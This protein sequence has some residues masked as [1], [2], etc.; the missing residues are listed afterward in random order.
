MWKYSIA[1][2]LCLN[3]FDGYTKKNKPTR[4]KLVVGVVL[5]QMRWDYLYRFADR[6]SEGG[7]KRLMNDGFNCDNTN[8]NYLPS[9]TAPGHASIYTGSVPALHGIAANDWVNIKETQEMYCTQDNSVEGIG[10]TSKAGKM[11]PKNLLATTITDELRLATNFKSKT[12]GISL[13]DRGAILPAGQSATAAFWFEGDE[14][15]FISSSYYMQQLP[16]WLQDFNKRKVTDSLLNIDWNTLFPI[17]TYAQSTSD[18][19]EYESALKGKKDA[20]FPHHLKE[21]INKD[22]GIIKYTPWGNTLTRLMAEAAIE[23]EQLGKGTQTDFLALSFSSTD[24]IGHSFAPNSIEVED[25][26]LRMDRE[27]AQLLI[28]LDK[29]VGKG[30]YTLFL[31]ADHGGAHNV[32]FLNDHKIHGKNVS[33]KK[34][35]N[36][37]NDTLQ[38]IFGKDS[39]VYLTNYQVYINDAYVGT[40]NI[41]RMK[42]IEVTKQYLEQQNDIAFVLNMKNSDGNIVPSKIKEMA[43][44]GYYPKRSGEL[45]MIFNPGDYL[46]YGSKGTTH[47]SWNPYDSHIPLLFYGWGIKKGSSFKPYKMVDIA[48]TLAA[49]LHIQEPNACIGTPITEALK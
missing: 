23:G 13:K 49:L 2:L 47:G 26:Y 35:M 19:N 40:H 28:F 16:N 14:G 6:Y 36:A 30:N 29:Q 20:T 9:Y 27:L 46:G 39:L 5:D 34:L 22:K 38:T 11:S 25:C 1:I 18:K 12:I 33:Q 7:F 31:T 4:P 41:D 17:H 44:N 8:I 21:Y 10:S 24:Y 37:V 3:T 42:L 48:P 43:I 32:T 15:K 45:L